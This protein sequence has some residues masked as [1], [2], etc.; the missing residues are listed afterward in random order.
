MTRRLS[1]LLAAGG[2]LAAG[3]LW[4]APHH[5]PAS[6]GQG[7]AAPAVKWEY[8][9]LEGHNQPVWTAGDTTIYAKD[10]KDLADRAKLTI[11][12]E[13][14]TKGAVLNALGAQGWELVSHAATVRT[15]PAAESQYYTFKRR[16]P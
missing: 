8:G 16:V 14:V 4:L 1:T 11:A 7:P 6:A 2:L 10:W 15:P 13:R 9:L 12:G 5:P 3:V